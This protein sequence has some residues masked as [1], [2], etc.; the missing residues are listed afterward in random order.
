MPPGTALVY[1]VQNTHTG[2][3]YVGSTVEPVRRWRNHRQGLVKGH[4]TSFLL[5]R[6]WDKH[7][8][9]AFEF[10]PLLVCSTENR[11][12]YEI[13][14]IKALGTY[15][16]LK[17]AGQP[18]AGSMRGLKHSATGRKNLSAGAKRRWE[19]T[20]ASKYDPM[21]EAAWKLVQAGVPRYKAYRSFDMSH[22]TFWKWIKRNGLKEP[23]NK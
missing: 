6:A 17:D 22:D 19:A 10:L 1:Q 7:G 20:R 2:N 11:F 16:L 3:A 13:A 18:P 14:A 5:Q 4:H 12:L 23:W 9:E 8:G 15:N 21:C